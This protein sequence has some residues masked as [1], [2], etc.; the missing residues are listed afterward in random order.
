MATGFERPKFNIGSNVPQTA[1]SENKKG[2][3]TD[4][5]ST[6]GSIAGSL[7]GAAVGT[8]IL[9]GIGTLLGGILGGA[10]GGAGGQVAENVVSQEKDLGKDVGTEALWGGLTGAPPLKAAKGLVMGGKALAS[11]AGK[12]AAN[13]ALKTAL[14]TSLFKSAAKSTAGTAA[15]AGS[16]LLGDAWGIRPGIKLSGIEL[17]PQNAIKL[18]NFAIKNIG[19]GKTASAKDVFAKTVS[20][21]DN[22]GSGIDETVKSIPAGTINTADLSKGISTKLGGMIGVDIKSN[23]IAKD[24]ISKVKT[25]KSPTELWQLRKEIDKNLISWGRN[26]AS[27]V[28]GAEQIARAARDDISK[29]LSSASPALKELNSQ[30][31]KALNIIKL[32]A[33]ATKTP[34]GMSLPVLGKVI[35]GGAAQ[36]IRAGAGSVLGSADSLAGSIPKLPQGLVGTA[37]RQ[38][39]V[40]QLAGQDQGAPQLDQALMQQSSSMPTSLFEQQISGMTEQSIGQESMSNDPYPKEALMYDIQRD[41]ENADKYF[42]YYANMQ[43][44]YGASAEPKLSEAQQARVDVKDLI[45]QSIG[46]L[47]SGN[48]KAGIIAGPLEQLKSRVGM[49]DQP[50]LEFNTMI[51]N[52]KATIAKARA[53][54]SF[55]AGEKKMLEQ[56]TPNVGD[57]EQQ[58]STKLMLLQRMFGGEVPN[59]SSLQDTLINQSQGY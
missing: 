15:K 6:G 24:I 48:V 29:A 44:V 39:G 22:V 26:P 17:S 36:K 56:Y 9:P 16:S 3:W 11:G 7:G 49:A 32:S 14:E 18:Q 27:V 34:K 58:L 21:L 57:S 30:Y 55:T 41:P 13:A 35:P 54:T 52:L 38:F 37:A 19:V 4:Q 10:L 2:F 47:Q 23:Q 20:Y 28:P 59:V 8:M 53:G 40:R 43:S 45:G 25:A 12:T 31:S 33:A 1:Q 50:T 46:M 51:S 5:I 42:K